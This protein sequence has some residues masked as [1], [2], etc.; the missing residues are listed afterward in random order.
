MLPCALATGTAASFHCL[1]VP[2][3]V[4]TVFLYFSLVKIPLYSGLVMPEDGCNLLKPFSCLCVIKYLFKSVFAFLPSMCC[5]LTVSKFYVL[6]CLKGVLHDSP[7]AWQ[8]LQGSIRLQSGTS[9]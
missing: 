6:R 8:A 1:W 3:C 5:M 2:S 9:R 7:G 4:C